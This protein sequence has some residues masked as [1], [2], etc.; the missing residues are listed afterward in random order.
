MKS[1]L[2]FKKCLRIYWSIPTKTTDK[3]NQN[4]YTLVM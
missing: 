4:E 3:N 1:E 2:L